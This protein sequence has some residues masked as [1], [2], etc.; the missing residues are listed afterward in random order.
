MMNE[1]QSAHR[2]RTSTRVE[3]FFASGLLKN[4][5]TGR[6]FCGVRT[7]RWA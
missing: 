2:R 4:D 5:G 7:F 3:A 1:S 6:V